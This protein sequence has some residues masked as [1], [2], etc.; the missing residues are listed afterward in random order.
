MDEIFLKRDVLMLKLLPLA[1][2]GVYVLKGGGRF[3]Q[4]Y[5]M[6]SVGERVIARIR[7]E[8]YAHIQGMPLAFFASL[9]SADL[10]SRVVTDVNRLA[11]LSSTVLVMAVRQVG[12]IVALL[13][14]MFAREWVLALI[15]VAVF[16]LA[17]VTVR[18]IGRSSTGSTSARSRRSPS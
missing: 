15:A 8:L 2:L 17:G 1:L 10:M 3:G 5:L 16:P 13:V 9:H 12:T 4:S 18:A 7:R 6:A 11:R 14:V